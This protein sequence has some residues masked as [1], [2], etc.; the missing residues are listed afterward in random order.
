MRFEISNL[1]DLKDVANILD[2]DDRLL[3]RFDDG[4]V[5][6]IRLTNK[7][8]VLHELKQNGH[9]AFIAT[10]PG[11]ILPIEVGNG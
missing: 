3:F 2:D 6:A 10:L 1:K 9:E 7:K 5:V 11:N 8:I 4:I